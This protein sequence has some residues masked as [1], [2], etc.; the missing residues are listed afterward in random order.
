MVMETNDNQ[1]QLEDVFQLI[2]QKIDESINCENY[3]FI[4]FF[5]L[6]GHTTKFVFFVV[7]FF[8]ALQVF[9]N[10]LHPAIFFVPLPFFAFLKIAEAIDAI[11]L[12]SRIK[13]IQT[14]LLQH[15]IHCTL[16]VLLDIATNFYHQQINQKNGNNSNS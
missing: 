6:Y 15:N 14:Q 4:N 9:I 16:D 2:E 12:Y 13:K 1:K 3:K 11:R 7:S 10:D 8:L 5:M